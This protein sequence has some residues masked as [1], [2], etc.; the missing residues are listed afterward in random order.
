M[1]IM[2]LLYKD[3]YDNI[4]TSVLA[5]NM[6]KRQLLSY[7]VTLFYHNINHMYK[8]NE[9]MYYIEFQDF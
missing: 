6:Y 9:R 8:A 2:V 7:N 3:Y 4:P 1:I 5:Y